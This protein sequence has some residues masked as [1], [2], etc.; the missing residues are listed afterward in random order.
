MAKVYVY[1]NKDG[2]KILLG[3]TKVKDHLVELLFALHNDKGFS[4]KKSVKYVLKKM[5][6]VLKVSEKMPPEIKG[7]KGIAV[8][9]AHTDIFIDT[10][11]EIST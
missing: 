3:S 10:F 2:E 8:F 6:K 7:L 1:E 11:V 5:N 9:K 4:Q